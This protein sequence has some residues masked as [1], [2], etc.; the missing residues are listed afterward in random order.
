MISCD[1]RALHH[2][3]WHMQV[4]LYS[5]RVAP[6]RAAW[7]EPEPDAPCRCY[8]LFDWDGLCQ[9]PHSGR[10]ARTLPATT[11][12]R[13]H[14][15]NKPG[16]FVFRLIELRAADEIKTASCGSRR[17]REMALALR[18]GCGWPGYRRARDAEY[19]RERRGVCR[20]PA[21]RRSDTHMRPH[22]I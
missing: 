15:A 20:L 17:L 5:L 3:G 6:V 8:R 9:L 18:G 14:E 2:A 4:S 11:A 1:T 19:R 16:T 7:L 22:Y 21:S 12:P 13:K 10:R